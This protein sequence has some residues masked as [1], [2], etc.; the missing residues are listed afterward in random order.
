MGLRLE[1]YRFLLRQGPVALSKGIAYARFIEY[2]R[3]LDA[4]ELKPGDKVLDVG[5]RYSPF[6]QLLALQCACS[7]V[8]VD[9]EPDF[10]ERQIAMARRVPRAKRLVDEGRLEFLVEDAGALSAPDRSFTKIAA[11]SVLEHIV[12]ETQVVRELARVLAPGGRLVISVPYDPW[13]DEPKYYRKNPYVLEEKERESFFMRY[14]NDENLRRRLVDPSGLALRGITY[15]GEPGFNAHNLL[16]G[17]HQIP[18]PLKRIFLQP[19]V[20]IL[21]PLLIR[22]LR[23]EQFRR[24]T[25]LYT[26]D[27]AVLTLER[28][29][30]PAERERAGPS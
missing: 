16:Y 27:T 3:V 10:R 26:A 24:K 14:Y 9:P 28:C 2:P 11:I 1:Y 7:V 4:L 6:P 19:L 12:D 30:T 29:I 25:K 15:F 23:P 5:S 8:A 13:R 18:W 21:A 20:P 17:N 22:D